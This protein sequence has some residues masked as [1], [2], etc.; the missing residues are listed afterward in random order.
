[1]TRADMRIARELVESLTN[2]LIMDEPEVWDII[3]DYTPATFEQSV[4]RALSAEPSQAL[5]HLQRAWEGSVRKIA[6]ILNYRFTS[7][8]PS[9]LNGAASAP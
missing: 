1:M 6:P 2:D 7:T 5:S 3:E 8:P 4:Q 9:G